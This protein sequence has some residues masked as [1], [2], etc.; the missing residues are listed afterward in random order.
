MRIV[1]NL[2][3]INLSL[4]IVYIL[5]L[6][7]IFTELPLAFNTLLVG[8]CIWNLA[9]TLLKRNKPN[10]LLANTLAGLS[11][12]VLFYDVGF[13]DTVTLFVAMLI[14]SSLFKLLQ[15]TTKKHYQT[16]TLLS[17][18]SLS[19][20]YLFS[21]SLFATLIISLLYILNFAVLALIESK[22]NLKIAVKGS[23]KLL[24]LALPI[25]I[26][27]LLLLPKVPAF[28]QLPGPKLAKTGLS[29]SVD[30]FDIAQLSNSDEL[31]FRAKFDEQ[32]PSPPYYWRA[33][34]HDEFD[35]KTWLISDIL[36]AKQVIGQNTTKL[37]AEPLFSY[38]IFAEP[39]AKPWLYGLQLSSSTHKDVKTT[40]DGLLLRKRFL[41]SSISYT[42]QSYPL[43]SALLSRSVQYQNA[44]LNLAKETNL[45][46]QTFAK[47]LYEQQNKDDDAFYSALY[48]YFAN[49]GFSYTLTPDPIT[50]SNTL[51]QFL[52]NNKRGFCGHYASTAAFM[53]RSVGIPARVVS[54]YLGGEY[55]E[56]NS[57]L[58][59]YQYD[60]HAWVEVYIK[61]KGWQI[62]D[63]TAVVSPERLNGSLSQHTQ[64]NNEFT[65]NL[66]FGLLRL[67]NIAGFNWLRLKL[68]N[69]DY[70][71]TSWVLGFNQQKQASLLNK[72]F[73]N[74]Q[75][76]QISLIVIAT[77][78]M[79]FICYFVYLSWPKKSSEPKH[80]LT[81]DYLKLVNWCEKQGI[82]AK[83]NQTPLQ[84]L[85]YAAH[86]QPE[87]RI[88]IE[89]FA[90][91][92]SDV[93]YRQLVFNSYRK[94]HSKDLIK[95]IKTK[96]KR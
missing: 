84:F 50:D 26:F 2:T 9:V 88:Y 58:S 15:A 60:A 34:I 38:Q 14:L 3:A 10:A 90:Q 19:T 77:V 78:C 51:D 27:L 4:S 86:K 66:S 8:L 96:M 32:R 28:W 12:I 13:S 94:K 91:L 7:F 47:R 57:Y 92:Y 76:W 72:L 71:W 89:Q 75:L 23:L 36:K 22:H 56:Q 30:P 6:S 70:Q 62:F 65:S 33:I 83:Q 87:K 31:V 54:G 73:G 93:R 18:F 79:T 63:A 85:D 44:Q 45:Q 81:K 68:E 16:I 67:S 29:E 37:G 69:L 5:V 61:N 17:F 82:V 39:A 49:N 59:V 35:G 48:E 21:Q 80:A 40:S 42:T 52:F 53:F 64:L 95:S 25:S 74:K 1:N 43:E 55:N 20:V 11:L 41:A 46:S 24:L